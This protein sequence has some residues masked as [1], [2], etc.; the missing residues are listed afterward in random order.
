ME[1]MLRTMSLAVPAVIIIVKYV[2]FLLLPASVS[3]YK[4]IHYIVI[5]LKR[6][7]TLEQIARVY[8]HL[9]LPFICMYMI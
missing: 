9:V 4:N 2:T 8:I 7:N 1:V 5:F 3:I 6:I